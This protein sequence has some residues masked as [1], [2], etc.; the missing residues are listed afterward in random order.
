[1]IYP[2]LPEGPIWTQIIRQEVGTSHPHY[3]EG[4]EIPTLQG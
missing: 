1:M 4:H 3:L 2:Y